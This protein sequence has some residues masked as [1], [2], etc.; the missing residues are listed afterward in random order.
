MA[1]PENGFDLY[2]KEEDRAKLAED[3]RCFKKLLVYLDIRS[4]FN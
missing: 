2:W 3:V 4:L 1:F